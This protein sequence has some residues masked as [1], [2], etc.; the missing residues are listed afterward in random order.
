MKPLSATV[1]LPPARRLHTAPAAGRSARDTAMMTVPAAKK[2]LRCPWPSLWSDI[3]PT[4]GWVGLRLSTSS[5]CVGVDQT[6]NGIHEAHGK[7]VR[8]E[9]E[10]CSFWWSTTPDTYHALMQ[11]DVTATTTQQ[12]VVTLK[13]DKPSHA[14]GGRLAAQSPP[15]E[16]A[17]QRNIPESTP[18]PPT[19]S[20]AP[21]ALREGRPPRHSQGRPGPHRT[22][23]GKE[24][25]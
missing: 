22:R 14:C 1:H 11:W 8:A 10:A 6:Q 23:R 24:A 16:H 3:T 7:G 12:T 20:P 2:K 19:L 5:D 13:I 4:T 15:A 18:F 17:Y 25:S 9:R 21:Q